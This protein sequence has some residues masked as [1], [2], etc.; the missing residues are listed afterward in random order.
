M[1]IEIIIPVKPVTKKNSQKIARNP[2][3]GQSFITQGDAYRKYERE[4]VRYLQKNYAPIKID[5]PVNVRCMYYMPTRR[6]VD[7]VNLLEATCDVLVHASILK[8]DNCS[9][10]VGHDGS[11]VLYDKE[12]PRTEIFIESVENIEGFVFIPS[13]KQRGTPPAESG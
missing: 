6:T 8:D 7:L 5:Y 12:N 4:A 10:I 3:T 13:R 2:Y 11:R 9:I 1:S